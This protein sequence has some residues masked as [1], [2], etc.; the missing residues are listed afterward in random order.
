MEISSSQLAPTD[1]ELVQ[2]ISQFVASM[3]HAL[4]E[5][6]RN[7]DEEGLSMYGSHVTCAIREKK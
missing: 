4:A 6:G 2:G 5:T 3:N 7:W 1:K